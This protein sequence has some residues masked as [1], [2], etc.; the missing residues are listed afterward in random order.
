MLQFPLSCVKLE[1]AS[2]FFSLSYFATDTTWHQNVPLLLVRM[3]AI[4]GMESHPP[5]AFVLSTRRDKKFP[6]VASKNNFI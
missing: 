3:L 5:R 4:S 6:R 2:L 1:E